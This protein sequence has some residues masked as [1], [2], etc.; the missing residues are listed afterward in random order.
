[1]SDP[2]PKEKRYIVRKFVM[3]MS[4]KEALEKERDL[5]PDEVFVDDEWQKGNKEF[6]SAVGFSVE[7]EGQ[8]GEIHS[9]STDTQFTQSTGGVYSDDNK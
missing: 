6:S 5:M 8:N 4:A 1:M 7:N 3:A 2:D 9:L